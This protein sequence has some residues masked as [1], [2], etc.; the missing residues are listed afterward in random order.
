MVAHPGAPQARP[1]PSR[2]RLT[3]AGFAIAAPRA[4]LAR[5][6]RIARERARNF[7]FAFAVLPRDRREA[8][9]AIYALCR[10]ADDIA[11]GPGSL[12]EKRAHLARLRFDLVAACEGRIRPSPA[13]PV[14]R[15][16]AHVIAQTSLSPEHLLRVVEGCE[17]DL[18][19]TRYETFAE[20]EGYLDRVASA[21]GRATMQVFGLDPERLSEYAK[22]GG[23][24]VQLTNIVRDVRE[25]AE[26]GRVYLPQEDLRRFGVSEQALCAA[27]PTDA[28]R[29]LVRFEV[30]RAR[31]LYARARAAIG[32]HERR[33]LLPLEIIVRI[34]S[35]LLDEI[36]RLD[37]DV[38]SRRVTLPTWRKAGL[39]LET[40]VR[41]KLGIGPRP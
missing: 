14:L 10:L 1:R 22:A 40:L 41:A 6:A 9:C 19:R 31:A 8:M 5:C 11:D 39:A 13:A 12:E 32:K 33:V 21:V 3:R 27:A 7:Y 35:R 23:Y 18:A 15:A 25:D 34:Y 17:M 37:F 4:E 20:L 38:L 2:L 26:R 24:A 36:E 30:E 29:A 28:V 16:V